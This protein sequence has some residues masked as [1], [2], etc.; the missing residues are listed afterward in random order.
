MSTLFAMHQRDYHPTIQEFLD[1]VDKSSTQGLIDPASSDRPR[2]LPA[3]TLKGYLQANGYQNMKKLL[4]VVFQDQEA[5]VSA[6]E[7]AR[8]CP[9]VFCILL[10]I[11]KASF[12][13]NF[14][15]RDHLQDNFLPFNAEFP[16]AH[17]PRC[18]SDRE[19]GE[20]LERFCEKQWIVCAPEIDFQLEER[21]FEENRILPIIFLEQLAK[22]ANAVCYKVILHKQ[23]NIL[24]G[25]TRNSL[26]SFLTWL[27]LET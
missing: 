22:G 21:T 1:W 26:V 2:F 4:R 25:S 5:P 20:F 18:P 11:G 6:E 17:F 16:P 7:V 15:Q 14:L 23:Y 9:R 19:E 12:I 27:Y 10:R 13:R 3:D 8:K 24:R